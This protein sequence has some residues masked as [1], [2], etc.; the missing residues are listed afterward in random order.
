MN[1]ITT[2]EDRRRKK[3]WNFER[4]V[5]RKLSLSAIRGNVH[6]H[7]PSIFENQK[8]GS[9]FVEDACVDFAIDAYLL[10]AEFSRFG[11]FG[12]SELLVRKRCK[13]EYDE[14]IHHLYNQL[15]GWVFKNGHDDHFYHLCESFIHYWW[16]K[17]FQEGEKRYRMKLH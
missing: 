8:I 7:F 3:Q 1:V 9:G 4:Q 17:G 6:N 15:S 16:E 13:Q 2:F 5:L 12:E 14:H 10:G 11:Y